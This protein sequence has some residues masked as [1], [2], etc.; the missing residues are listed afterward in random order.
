M[1]AGLCPNAG[2]EGAMEEL[3]AENGEPKGV[4]AGPDMELFPKTEG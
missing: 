1:G 4:A 3:G 2:V